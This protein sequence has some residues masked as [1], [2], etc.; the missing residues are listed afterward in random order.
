MKVVWNCQRLKRRKRLYSPHSVVIRLGERNMMSNLILLG[1]SGAQAAREDGRAALLKMTTGSQSLVVRADCIVK[2]RGRGGTGGRKGATYK[3]R[4][5]ISPSWRASIISNAKIIARME[6]RWRIGGIRNPFSAE[7]HSHLCY[8]WDTCLAGEKKYGLL[9]IA[10]L[11][12]I[13]FL[14][15]LLEILMYVFAFAKEVEKFINIC[16]IRYLSPYQVV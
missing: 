5:T 12:E 14:S 7:S 10:D 4:T 9:R 6:W 13:Y 3:K 1:M 2:G 15:R 11:E 16:T 8:Y